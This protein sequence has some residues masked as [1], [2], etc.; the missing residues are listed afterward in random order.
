VETS[1]MLQDLAPS[2]EQYGRVALLT[3]LTEQA[4]PCFD[5]LLPERWGPASL[6]DDADAPR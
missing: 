3:K 6:A 4:V 5:K 2:L 1:Y